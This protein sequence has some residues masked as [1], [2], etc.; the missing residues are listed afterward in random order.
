MM[1]YEIT[2]FIVSSFIVF[3]ST[4]KLV[5]RDSILSEL[6]LLPTK[7]SIPLVLRQPGIAFRIMFYVPTTIHIRMDDNPLLT[8]KHDLSS[9][10]HIPLYVLAALNQSN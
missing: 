7:P 4:M 2:D 8:L 3:Y 9:F 1:I 6:S 5:C 10:Q